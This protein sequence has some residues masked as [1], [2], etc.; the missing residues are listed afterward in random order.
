M[1]K[2]PSLTPEESLIYT[3]CKVKLNNKDSVRLHDILKHDLDWSI[4]KKYA[5]QLGMG[6]LLFKHLSESENKHN[7]PDEILF[8]LRK[9]YIN[10]LG[11]NVRLYKEIDDI[12]DILNRSN[13]PIVLLK[14]AFLAHY[15]YEDIALRPMGDI[16][17]LVREGDCRIVLEK[18]KELGYEKLAAYHSSNFHEELLLDDTK[19]LTP[20]VKPGCCPVEVHLDIFPKVSHD[21]RYMINTWETTQN[22]S[23]NGYPLKYLSPEYQI[24]YLCL[25]L[26]SHIN[27]EALDKGI[28]LF[29]FSDIHEIIMRFRDK[30]NWNSF[31]SIVSSI[32][33]GAQVN[34]ILTY[35][36]YYWNTPIPETVLH[37][38][39]KDINGSC[40]T[41]NIRSIL[42]GTKAKKSHIHRYIKKTKVPL[43]KETEINSFYYL[44]KEIFPNRSNLINR[45]DL[46]DSL[47]VYIYYAIHPWK[48]FMR[49]VTSTCY[50]IVQHFKNRLT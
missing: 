45:Y 40:L 29:W 27:D 46:N 44:W 21:S 39:E 50:H 9:N 2:Q 32:G 23:L 16:D 12:L 35:I 15:I 41:S 10:Q 5:S 7:V 19:H 14:G 31:Y 49:A 43:T 18:L 6:T 24:L 42:D 33:V 26:C 20:M 17:I 38:Q 34:T 22:E 37:C 1:Y 47:I 4:I 36:R 28:R 13:I 3:V 25:H 48:L 11:R 8:S 30:I